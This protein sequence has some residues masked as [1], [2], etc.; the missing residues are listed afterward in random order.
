MSHIFSSYAHA[1]NDF[2]ELMLIKLNEGNIETWVDHPSL[3]AGTDWRM[4]TEILSHGV[5]GFFLSV[6]V[7]QKRN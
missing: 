6:S 3:K 7:I 5:P 1:D 2:V 4:S